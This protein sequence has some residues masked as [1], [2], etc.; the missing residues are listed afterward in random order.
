MERNMKKIETDKAIL[1]LFTKE[2]AVRPITKLVG[3]YDP[4]EVLTTEYEY[5]KDEVA[6]KHIQEEVGAYLYFD[7]VTKYKSYLI[8]AGSVLFCTRAKYNIPDEFEYIVV[9]RI[10]QH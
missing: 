4:I 9:E 10:T 1:Y 8:Y 3:R 5:V 6:L 7:Q 2:E